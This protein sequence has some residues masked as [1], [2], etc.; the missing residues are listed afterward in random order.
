MSEEVDLTKQSGGCG[1]NSPAVTLMKTWLEKG[2]NRNIKV[3]ATPGVQVDQVE[4]WVAA[5]SEQGDK[6]IEKK[7]EDGKVVFTISLP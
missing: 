6:L 3:V 7:I 1:A 4:M 5:M 2:G